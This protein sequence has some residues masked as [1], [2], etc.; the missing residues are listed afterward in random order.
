MTL[1]NKKTKEP[2]KVGDKLPDFRGEV[3]TVTGW[4]EPKHEGSTGRIAVKRGKRVAEY[5]PSVFDAE[6]KLH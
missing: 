1:V 5:Y 6:F 4:T 2:I 3:W